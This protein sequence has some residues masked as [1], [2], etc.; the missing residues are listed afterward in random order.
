MDNTIF[1][2][3]SIADRWLSSGFCLGTSKVDALSCLAWQA[4]SAV[5]KA[6]EAPR[7]VAPQAQ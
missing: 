5:G 3:L 1:P 4:D 7:T 6:H 2:F